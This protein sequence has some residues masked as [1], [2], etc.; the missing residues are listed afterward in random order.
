MGKKKQMDAND[1]STAFG[2]NFL[3]RCFDNFF[4]IL[5]F[6]CNLI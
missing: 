3:H 1:T 5:L 2:L 6:N 4:S